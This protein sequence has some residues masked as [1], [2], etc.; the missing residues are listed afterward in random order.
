[1]SSPQT[2]SEEDRRVVSGWA[3]NCAER[4]LGIFEAQAPGDRRPRNAI[5]RA[6]AF[7]RGELDV[8]E[9]IRR[10]FRDGAAAREAADPAAKAAAKAAGQAAAIPHM[11][12]HALGAAAYAAKAV[13]LAELDSPDAAPEEIRWQLEHISP[14]VA[15]ALR[16]L[17]AVGTN[18]AGPLGPGLLARG[19]LGTI[20]PD[21][22]AGVADTKGRIRAEASTQGA[23]F[24][25]P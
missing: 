12:A 24:G 2:L 22:Q 1:M 5:R 16:S 17:P 21:L 3:A 6:R 14:A 11:G 20:I 10:R 9:E 25:C 4:V 7:S 8:A 18:G 15:A 23:Q 13:S 19:T